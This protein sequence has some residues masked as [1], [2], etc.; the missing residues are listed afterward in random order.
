MMNCK[1]ATRLLSDSQERDLS[2]KERLTLKIHVMMCS[3]C[4]NFGLQMHMLRDFAG[5]FSRGS[6]DRKGDDTA[7]Q[8]E[9][10]ENNKDN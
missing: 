5:A 2:L 3:G 8:N 7:T 1:Q 6:G 4:N 10:D 9:P